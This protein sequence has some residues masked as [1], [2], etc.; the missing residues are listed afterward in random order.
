MR[1]AEKDAVRASFVSPNR[2]DPFTVPLTDKLEFLR[3]MDTKPNQ[4]GVAQRG[5]PETS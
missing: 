4:S 1:L 2:I 5:S 3:M